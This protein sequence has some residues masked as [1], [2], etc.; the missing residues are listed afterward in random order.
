MPTFDSSD[1]AVEEPND[2]P[3][4]TEDAFDSETSG[5]VSQQ[6]AQNRA[7]FR[8]YDLPTY[9]PP[10][11]RDGVSTTAVVRELEARGVPEI[12]LLNAPGESYETWEV[13]VSGERAG[14]IRRRRRAADART[15]YDLTSEEFVTLVREADRSE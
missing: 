12:R 1:R 9:R 11:F 7:L 3:S 15:V 5:V 10:R 13:Q 6:L 8:Q 4:E 14:T 2:E